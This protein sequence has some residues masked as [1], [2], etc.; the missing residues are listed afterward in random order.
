M[1]EAELAPAAPPV[2]RREPLVAMLLPVRLEAEACPL[3]ILGADGRSVARAYGDQD[4]DYAPRN[5]QASQRARQIV[6]A[7]NHHEALVSAL[8]QIIFALPRNRDWLD[9]ELEKYARAV[10]REVEGAQ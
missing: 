7:V 8:S 4:A 6:V 10:L 2:E 9:P 5:L 3:V 1:I